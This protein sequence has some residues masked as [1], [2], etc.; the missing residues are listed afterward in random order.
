MRFVTDEGGPVG[1]LTEPDRS[2]SGSSIASAYIELQ[3]AI[4]T[5]MTIVL[6]VN[7]LILSPDLGLVSKQR[8]RL[9]DVIDIRS[10][11]EDIAGDTGTPEEPSAFLGIIVDGVRREIDRLGDAVSGS[12][13]EALRD[14]IQSY[15]AET[16]EDTRTV[17][18]ALGKTRFGRIGF[19]G[20]AMHYDAARDISTARR[21]K[22]EHE[23]ALSD[24]QQ[25]AFVDA[26][27]ALNRYTTAKEYFR[28]LYIRE[29][30]VRFSRAMLYVA[31]PSLA[32]AHYAT[33]VIGPSVLVES[34]LGVRDLLWFESAAFAVSIL[35]EIVIVS[36]VARLVTLS[37]T[38]LF[39]NPFSKESAD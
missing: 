25:M 12:D 17:N 33:G 28:T 1:L 34:T 23:D 37:E 15:V 6:A 22:N 3:T 39:A 14:D 8:Q 26:I 31:I 24:A 4:V 38:S 35:P 13:D 7:P 9:S 32:V 29:E 16:K 18:E 36:Y 19:I 10:E 5:A 2:I 11:V 21:L 20:A 30:F 27:D